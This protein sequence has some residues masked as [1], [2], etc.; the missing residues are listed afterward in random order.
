MASKTVYMV[1][2]FEMHRQ[3]LT[4]TIKIEVPSESAAKKRAES[5]A[6]RLV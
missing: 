4:P 2:T 5:I 1:Q 3:V 6:S